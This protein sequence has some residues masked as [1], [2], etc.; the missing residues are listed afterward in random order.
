MSDLHISNHFSSVHTLF[1][2]I[3]RVLSSMEWQPSRIIYVDQALQVLISIF[4][5]VINAHV[6]VALEGATLVNLLSTFLH[7]GDGS[8]TSFR[9]RA[10]F[11]RLAEATWLR[12]QELAPLR[13]EVTLSADLLDK[14]FDWVSAAQSAVM[15]VRMSGARSW[16]HAYRSIGDRRDKII[17]PRLSAA[18]LTDGRRCHG[19]P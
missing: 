19:W 9:I 12:R 13:Q 17:L 2:N 7:K 10:H 18:V 8:E 5:Y 6:G 15:I 1:R 14:V 11:A 16:M 3:E 4:I